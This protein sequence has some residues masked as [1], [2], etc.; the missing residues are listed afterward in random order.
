MTAKKILTVVGIYGLWILLLILWTLAAFQVQNLVL[1][2]GI[3]VIQ[4]DSLRPTGWS[5]DTLSGINRCGFLILGSLWLGMAVFTEKYLR[6]GAAEQQL[7][8]RAFQLAL[9][10][11]AV[12]LLST[13]LLFLLS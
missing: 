7:L 6:E 1:Y 2:L 4:S 11:G 3:L 13:G 12:Y 8:R 10:G 9:I 5:T